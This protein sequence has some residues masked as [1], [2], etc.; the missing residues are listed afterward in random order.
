MSR[1][2]LLYVFSRL[3]AGSFQPLPV[4]C[5]RR[6]SWLGVGEGPPEGARHVCDQYLRR[7]SPEARS[8]V[9]ALA[10]HHPAVL[11]LSGK[12]PEVSS[13]QAFVGIA[14]PAECAKVTQADLRQAAELCGAL[15][16]RAGVSHGSATG[17][18][19]AFRCLQGL[20]TG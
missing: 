10:T 19:L 17:G 3:S 20:L 14:A 18:K 5:H 11:A 12:P 6:L 2:R 9:R 8:G 4:R 15:S 13:G 16:H 1:R 7:Q